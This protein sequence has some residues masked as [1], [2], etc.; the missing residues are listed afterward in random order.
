MCIFS[1]DLTLGYPRKRK[2][3]SENYDRIIYREGTDRA[4]LLDVWNI[5]LLNPMPEERL[6]YPTQKPV[7]LLKRI[8]KASS[9]AGDIVLDP[10]CRCSATVEAAGAL[11]RQFGEFT[12][13]RLLL[14]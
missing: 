8:V 3:E 13:P 1:L 12:Y 7:K 5:S 10:F 2:F 11:K 14:T 9:N 4:S 6:G